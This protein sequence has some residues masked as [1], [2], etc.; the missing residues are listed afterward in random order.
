ML[1]LSKAS[2]GSYYIADSRIVNQRLRTPLAQF[3]SSTRF[4][5]TVL[6]HLAQKWSNK[7]GIHCDVIHIVDASKG[8]PAVRNPVKMARKR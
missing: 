4:V 1:E 3:G 2:N 8:I 7:K 6:L 5:T